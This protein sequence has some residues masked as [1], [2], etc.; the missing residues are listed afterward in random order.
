MVQMLTWNLL[1]Y[2]SYFSLFYYILILFIFINVLWNS[3][4]FHIY[5]CF[6]IFFF[7]SYL[8]LFYWIF[9]LFKFIIVLWYSLNINKFPLSIAIESNS[10]EIVKFLVENGADV[11][12]KITFF[13][14]IFINVL[15]HSHS[16][17]IYQCFMEFSFFS[18]LSLFYAILF[19]FKFIIVLWYSLNINKCP[20]SIA[21]ESNSIEIVK[22]LV[23]H[24]ATNIK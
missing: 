17:H 18:Y 1:S 11:N 4:S 21:I 5:Q 19:L 6:I 23:D 20:L 15:L 3:L 16:F 8:S 22:F 2:F 10:I 12:M 7:F 14:F 24:G 9:F 13:L